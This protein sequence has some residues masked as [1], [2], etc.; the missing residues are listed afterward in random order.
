VA[1]AAVTQ[2]IGIASEAA[3]TTLTSIFFMSLPYSGGCFTTFLLSHFSAGDV[4]L[5][6][7]EKSCQLTETRQAT[8]RAHRIVSTATG[9]SDR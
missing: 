1:E 9:P 7:S 5:E 3:A 4:Y 8:N 6:E 2:P